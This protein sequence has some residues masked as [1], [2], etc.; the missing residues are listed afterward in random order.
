MA[1]VFRS[2]GSP[3]TNNEV[4]S[5]I[6]QLDVGTVV[7]SGYTGDLD[8]NTLYTSRMQHNVTKHDLPNSV[9]SPLYI[10][11]NGM[12][13]I[14]V[15]SGCQ[16]TVYLGLHQNGSNALIRVEG[17]GTTNTTYAVFRSNSSTLDTMYG[18]GHVSYS[19]NESTTGNQYYI[20]IP[21]TGGD[22]AWIF[23]FRHSRPQG[24]NVQF[25]FLGYEP[26]LAI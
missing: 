26:A 23:L 8:V 5:N 9:G 25:L 16:R 21:I 19:S 10:T 20:P 15:P 7:Q 4:D 1:L 17:T 3:L 12:H 18:A 6:S 13:M 11:C 24:T 22:A 2:S 14:N